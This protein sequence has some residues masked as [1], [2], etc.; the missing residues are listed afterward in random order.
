MWIFS[1]ALS[2]NGTHS[3]PSWAG[4]GSFTD[5]NKEK[6]DPESTIEYM[7]SIFSPITENATVQYLLKLSQEASREVGQECTIVT[8]WIWLWPKRHFFLYDK[9]HKMLVTLSWFILG[10]HLTCVYMAAPGKKCLYCCI[11]KEVQRIGGDHC[12]IRNLC[13]WIYRKGHIRQALQ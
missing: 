5:G 13:K 11:W 3:V 9:T 4:W 6:N 1:R 7:V 8:F 10:F 2:Q 12:R